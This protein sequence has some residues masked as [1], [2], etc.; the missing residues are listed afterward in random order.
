MSFVVPHFDYCAQTWHLCNT[1]SAEKLEKGNE[2]AVRFVFRDKHITHEERLKLLG[3]RTLMEQR[4]SKILCSVF[5]L[6]NNKTN[7]ESLNE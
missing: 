7:P 2:R 4:L 6:V 1:C 3:R 5:K